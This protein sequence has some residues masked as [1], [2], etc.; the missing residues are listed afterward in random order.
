MKLFLKGLLVYL[1]V[2]LALNVLLS[3]QFLLKYKEDIEANNPESSL[4][5]ELILETVLANIYLAL[6]LAIPLAASMRT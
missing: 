3:G 4:L 1:V 2:S 6:L 5:L